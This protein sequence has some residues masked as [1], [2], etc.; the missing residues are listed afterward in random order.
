V[1][2]TIIHFEKH[3]AEFVNQHGAAGYAVLCVTIFLETACILFAWLPGDSL[4]FAAGAIA[5]L[6]SLNIVL[7][8]ALL[9]GAAI[10]G[11]WLNY[12]IGRKFG[13][14]ILAKDFRF[15]KRTHVTKTEIFFEKH[16]PKAIVLARF[17]PIVRTFA[18]F[19]A[20]IGHMDRKTFMTYNIAGG[21]GWIISMTLLGYFFGNIEA[22]KHNFTAVILGIV[23]ISV[24]PVLVEFLKE[25]KHTSAQ[26]NP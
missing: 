21:I 4:L 3:L 15:L 20:G 12:W 23:A 1:L 7:L 6:G 14:R 10:I 8:I 13:D 25:R 9:I 11:D 17:V 19:M 5:A 2:D 22:V 24:L 16:G 18:P 26:P